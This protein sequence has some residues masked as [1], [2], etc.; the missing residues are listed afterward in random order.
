MRKKFCL[1]FL[2]LLCGCAATKLSVG[3]KYSKYGS[4]VEIVE[5]GAK[6]KVDYLS[7]NF[8]VSDFKKNAALRMWSQEKLDNEIASLPEGGHV[9]VHI[10]G[11]TIGSA[12][13]KW[14]EYVVT[15]LS[16]KEIERHEGKND[17]PSHTT[18]RYKTVWWNTGAF[19]IQKKI[20]SPFFIYVIDNL[21]DKRSKF[22][23]YP[24]SVF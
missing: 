16:N 8:L 15:A 23:I 5:N 13:T 2:F 19:S 11:E 6:A 10:T 9:L 7:Y 22:K 14:W 20:S 24:N 17:I 21:L 3:E 4:T 18:S 1:I 12:N